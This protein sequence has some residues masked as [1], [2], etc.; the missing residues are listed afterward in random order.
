MRKS[1]F[2]KEWNFEIPWKYAKYA[3][4]LH[5]VVEVLF[6]NKLERVGSHAAAIISACKKVLY[7]GKR[8]KAFATYEVTSSL[9]KRICA[10]IYLNMSQAYYFPSKGYSSMENHYLA[11]LLT[12]TLL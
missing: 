12:S 2:L 5:A 3:K 4:L 9:V 1:C 6:H 10:I 8:G 7:H 11:H